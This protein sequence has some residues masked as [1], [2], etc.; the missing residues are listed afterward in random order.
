VVTILKI[1]ILLIIP[2]GGFISEDLEEDWTVG[3]SE[4]SS[5]SETAPQTQKSA[6]THLP[7]PRATPDTPGPAGPSESS[8]QSREIRGNIAETNI[9]VDSRA[10]KPIVKAN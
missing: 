2:P 9:I 10:R 5:S 8:E 7:T 4:S 6:P 3:D 1:L